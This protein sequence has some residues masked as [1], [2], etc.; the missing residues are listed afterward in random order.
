MEAIESSSTQDS[1]DEERDQQLKHQHQHRPQR[2][3]SQI[4]TLPNGP[5]FL[6]HLPSY[7]T[8]TNKNIDANDEVHTTNYQIANCFNQQN[9]IFL[10]KI[11]LWGYLRLKN[12]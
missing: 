12:T 3:Q 11:S 7:G 1:K 2:S 10:C 4:L 9:C 8:L 5:D 6:Q